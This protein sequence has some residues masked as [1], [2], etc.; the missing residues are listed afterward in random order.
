MNVI[1]RRW[2]VGALCVL[3]PVVSS[4]GLPA[5]ADEGGVSSQVTISEVRVGLSDHGPVVLLSAD[6]KTI[7]VFVDQTVAASIQAAL[8]GERLP[9][10]LSHE[11]MHTILEALGGRVIRT[12]IT[13]KAGTFYGSL[14]VAFQGQEKVF[15]SRSSDSIALAIH[16]HAP[17]LVGRDLLESAGTP[18]HEPKPQTL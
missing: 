17:I 8:T 9:R 1:A 5:L 2:L 3:V 6:G 16:F 18:S 11:L 15:D 10:P 14:T 12:V 13:L 4:G 7:P